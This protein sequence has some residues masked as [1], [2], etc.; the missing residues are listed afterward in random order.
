MPV[1]LRRIPANPL[2]LIRLIPA[3]G[4]WVDGFLGFFAV[5]HSWTVRHSW[6]ALRAR[7]DT[8]NSELQEITVTAT[9]RNTPASEVPA[10]VTVLDRETLSDAGRA[11]FQDV[12]GLVPNLNWAGDT[13]L[14]RYFSTARHR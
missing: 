11:N 5:P 9:L 8:D 6:P 4:A 14:P 3:E 1:A 13:S 12:L 7:A 10:S 2:N